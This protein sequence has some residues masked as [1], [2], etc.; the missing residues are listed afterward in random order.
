MSW[1]VHPIIQLLGRAFWKIFPPAWQNREV[2]K[3]TEEELIAVALGIWLDYQH[4]YE[5]FQGEMYLGLPGLATSFAPED[6]PTDYLSFVSAAE[7]MPLNTII[8][9]LGGMEGRNHKPMDFYL[10]QN[11]SYQPMVI[12]HDSFGLPIRSKHKNWPNE[13]ALT[14][15]T[16][17]SGLWHFVSSDSS[18][19]WRG[20]I[21]FLR[22][23]L[24]P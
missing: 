24:G 21:S 3:L 14:S 10:F 19:N 17:D 22:Q 1:A 6:L 2:L 8:S 5:T 15:I 12:V 18:Q 20:Y 23:K 9:H 11:E 13:L 16:S 7:D 4:R